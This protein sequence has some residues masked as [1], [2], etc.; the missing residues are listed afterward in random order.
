[1]LVEMKST[2]C[3]S[4]QCCVGLVVLGRQAVS[5]VRL[6]NV[7]NKR[8]GEDDMPN[9]AF[10]TLPELLPGFTNC[11]LGLELASLSVRQLGGNEMT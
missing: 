3:D 5:G 4:G 11:N 8:L 9:Q 1:M 6:V 10:L 2:I 7:M